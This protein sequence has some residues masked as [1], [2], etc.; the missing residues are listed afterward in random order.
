MQNQHNV[1]ACRTPL[2]YAEVAEGASMNTCQSCDKKGSHHLTLESGQQVHLCDECY[3]AWF[4]KRLGLDY[5]L[6]KHPKTITVFRN[7]YSVR[8]EIASSGVAYFAYRNKGKELESFCFIGPFTMSGTEA[9]RELKDKVA[10]RTYAPTLEDGILND[11]GTIGIV[12]NELDPDEV[13]FLIDG[14]RYSA[15]QYLDL[16]RFHAGSNLVYLIE[17]RVP[18]PDSEW[19]TL[20]EHLPKEIVTD[21]DEF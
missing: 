12:H 6:Y 17:P 10:F 21:T 2:L 18:G 7:R 14:K 4:C 15:V 19:F 9:I 1:L 20:A 8:V 5:E 13:E 3:N 16:L 11:M